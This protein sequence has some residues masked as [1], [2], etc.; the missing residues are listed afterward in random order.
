MIIEI[1]SAFIAS[2]AFGIVF[3]IKGKNLVFS[4]LCGAIG[5]FAYKLSLFFRIS[6][7]L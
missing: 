2:F 7:F 1:I 5:W 6:Y 4:A 3:S